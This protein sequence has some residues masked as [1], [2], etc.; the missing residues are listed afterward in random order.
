MVRGGTMRADDRSPSYVEDEEDEEEEVASLVGSRP[1]A[2]HSPITCPPAVRRESPKPSLGSPSSSA[3]D[4]LWMVLL[5][6]GGG[7]SDWLCARAGSLRWRLTRAVCERAS[8]FSRLRSLSEPA[9]AKTK[10]KGWRLELVDMLS[11]GGRVE[12]GQRLCT[13]PHGHGGGRREACTVDGGRWV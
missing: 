5:G 11:C 1:P 6:G 8:W 10:W 7:A 12:P 2:L 3:V 9:L 13:R 4:D